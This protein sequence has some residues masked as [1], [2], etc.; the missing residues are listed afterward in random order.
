MSAWV[1]KYFKYV[2]PLLVQNLI[3][4][5][6]FS[7][8]PKT[9]YAAS[10]VAVTRGNYQGSFRVINIATAVC[11]NN[12]VNSLNSSNTFFPHAKL[13]SHFVFNYGPRHGNKPNMQYYVKRQLFPFVIPTALEWARQCPVVAEPLPADILQSNVISVQSRHKWCSQTSTFIHWFRWSGDAV[14]TNLTFYMFMLQLHIKK[15]WIFQHEM[16]DVSWHGYKHC[17]VLWR[18]VNFLDNLR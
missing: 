2:Q 9:M 8:Q 18:S 12:S 14:L 7:P 6:T 4:I 17:I 5:S 10:S 13:P 16:V 11:Q 1:H 3:F 15:L